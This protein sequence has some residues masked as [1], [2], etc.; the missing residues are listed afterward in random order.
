MSLSYYPLL[1]RGMLS[2]GVLSR[3][4]RKGG[5]FRDYENRL[6]GPLQSSGIMELKPFF[7]SN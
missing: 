4:V 6:L 5:A 2:Y 1:L 7:K 3:T